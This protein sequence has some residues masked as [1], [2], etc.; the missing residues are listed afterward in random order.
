MS[1]TGPVSGLD[2]VFHFENLHRSRTGDVLI[3][4]CV[5]SADMP[6]F[7]GHFP[8]MPIMPAVAQIEM[9]QS[10]LQQHAGRSTIIAGGTGLKFT[11]PIAP[12][13]I[14]TIRLQRVSGGEISFAVEHDAGVASRGRLKLTGGALG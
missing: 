13:D 4:T 10:L 9:I 7:S 12:G 2:G 8:G 1:M 5:I 3:C 11:S 14:L 6:F